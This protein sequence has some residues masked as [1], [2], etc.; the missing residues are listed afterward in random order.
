[1]KRIAEQMKENIPYGV[2][3]DTEVKNAVTSS[4]HG[5]YGLIKRAI[6]RGE[7]IHLRRGLYAFSKK[8][9]PH[10]LNAFEVAQKIYSPSYVS[11]ESALSFHGWIPEGV[12]T[13]TSVSAR[14]SKEF[15]TP[16]G[17]FSYSRMPSFNFIGV[18]RIVEDTAV[19]F[20]ATPTKA[21]IDFVYVYKKNWRGVR[22][23][24]ESL[25]IE[26]DDLL[27]LS[28][29]TLDAIMQERHGARVA[30]FIEGLIEELKL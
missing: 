24:I 25:R 4:A 19:F 15:T 14:R 2:F 22:P 23:L 20:M 21:L 13:I 29:E 30:R 1:M 3:T 28:K 17:V 18:E 11:L 10:A 5:R 16:L 9:L 12:P 6:A 8:Y 27:A 26:Q 7:L